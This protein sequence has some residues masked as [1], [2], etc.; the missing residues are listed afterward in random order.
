[1]KSMRISFLCFLMV[2]LPI[3]SGC[4]MLPRVDAVPEGKQLEA[5]VSDLENVRYRVGID[6]HTLVDE[7]VASYHQEMAYRKSQGLTGPLA[8]VNFLAISGGGDDGAYTAGLLNGWTR[9]GTRP[10][11]K[12]VTGVSTG[13]LI[14]PFAFLGPDYDDELKDFYTNTSQ[15]DILDPRWLLSALF[16]DAM[17]DNR[18]LWKL[19]KKHVTR[20]LL[21]KIGA[22]YKQKGRLLLVGTTDLDARQGVI[23]NMTKIAA[24]QDP[25]ALELFHSIMIASAAIPAAFP[26]VMIDVE[27]DG[28]HHQ[29]MHVDGGTVAQ[30]FVY[31][32]GLHIKELAKKGHVVRERNLYVIRNSRLDPEWGNTERRLMTIA[33]RAISS[34]IHSQGIGDLYRIYTVTQR[35]GVKYNLGF[36][37]PTFDAEH[38]EQFDTEYMR[39]LYKVGYDEAVKGYPW[40]HAPPGYE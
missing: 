20:E 19:I 25:R 21:D 36:I 22:E 13:G 9:A 31:P 30:V 5:K 39:K 33:G 6:T 10:E 29:E 37:P 18:P 32:P 14:A 8:P 26:P 28:K 17:A 15:K 23:W 12:L 16:S 34:L 4:G 11:F 27:V 1:M 7:A 24:S 40:R 35:D 3:L 2:V 38:K